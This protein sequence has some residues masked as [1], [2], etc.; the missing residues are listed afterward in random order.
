MPPVETSTATAERPWSI[1]NKKL[2]LGRTPAAHLK[3]ANVVGFLLDNFALLRFNCRTQPGLC[4]I[5]LTTPPFFLIKYLARAF[6]S[7]LLVP[8]KSWFTTAKPSLTR[9]RKARDL[10]F[11]ED[12]WLLRHVAG[13][14]DICV[15]QGVADFGNPFLRSAVAPKHENYSLCRQVARIMHLWRK[16]IRKSGV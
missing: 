14:G 12:F 7:F 13:V 11:L 1:K 8:L 9:R 16:G 15:C 4:R 10:L 6:P 2:G 5:F 3:I